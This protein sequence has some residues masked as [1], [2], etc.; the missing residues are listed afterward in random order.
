[1]IQAKQI[2]PNRL[3]LVVDDQ[4]LN[5]DVLSLVLE[6]G[7]EIIYAAN[8]LEALEA[9]Q[10][11][12][13]RLSIILLDLNMPV[14]NGFEVLKKVRSDEEMKRIPVI[15]LTSEK[16]A[17]L[18]ALKMGAADFITKPFDV[19]EVVLARVERVIEISEGRELISGAERDPITQLYNRGFFFHYADQIHRFHPDWHMD[20]L[21]L[22]IDRFHFLN[23]LSGRSYGDGILHLIGD[24][25]QAFLQHTKGIAAR[26]EADR[27]DIFCQHQDG[28]QEI[29]EQIQHRVNSF[30]NNDSIRLRMGVKPW[31]GGITPAM[32]FEHARVAC[33]MVRG[34]IKTHLMIYD[35][36]LRM[37][38]LY[39]Q[40]L[41]NDLNEAVLQR[42][43]QVFFQPKY[44]IQSEP[45]KLSSAEALIRWNHPVYG[46]IYPGDFVPLFEQNGL[47]HLVDSY[48]MSETVRQIALWRDKFGVI[49]PVSVNLS[50][51]DAVDPDLE[52][53]LL[54]LVEENGLA[55]NALKLEVTETAYTENASQLIDVFNRLREDGFEIEVDDFGSGYSSLN[56]I[57]SL[58]IDVLKMDMKFIQNIEAND[59]EMRLVELILDIA[60]Y[61]RV[62]VVAEGVETEAQMELLKNASCDLVQGFYFSK[63]LP[64]DELEH[65]I[66]REIRQAEESS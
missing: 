34:S 39:Q 27:F 54:K 14:M 62:P 43:L 13:H 10:E 53:K 47:I 33:N 41:M 40:R 9:I 52:K 12:L 51:L 46:M 50:R 5:R 44:N 2:V 26:Y 49:L 37:K 42:Q 31:Q 17:E 29:L 65:L 57:S 32:M 8:G 23:E 1:M 36:A 24:E 55:P 48:V 22:D 6:N 38:E 59:V 61:L 7:Y 35:D 28:Y 66:L 20:A 25:I 30:T 45:A 63:P 15:V 58:P 18:K 11:N 64:A 3:V 21:V 4:E 56:M 60:K 19:H 16:E